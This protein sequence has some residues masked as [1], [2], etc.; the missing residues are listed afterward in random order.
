MS[1]GLDTFSLVSKL[2]SLRNIFCD[3]LILSFCQEH[4]Q[5]KSCDFVLLFP[6]PHFRVWRN[7]YW[8]L[9]TVIPF[10]LLDQLTWANCYITYIYI[11]IS[12]FLQCVTSTPVCCLV[13]CIQLIYHNKITIDNNILEMKDICIPKPPFVCVYHLYRWKT[14]LCCR[15]VW[16]SCPTT[17]NEAVDMS[18]MGNV[19]GFLYLQLYLFIYLVS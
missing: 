17:R 13:A 10:V 12:P 18:G 11:Y 7:A 2:P 8:H 19:A 14:S 15:G 16:H 4:I 1:K 9:H 5:S 3:P 6:V